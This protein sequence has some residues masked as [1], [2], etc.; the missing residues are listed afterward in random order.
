M[1]FRWSFCEFGEAASVQED[2]AHAIGQAVA[3]E[4][5]LQAATAE[6]ARPGPEVSAAGSVRGE[7]LQLPPTRRPSQSTP[8]VSWR[9][10]VATSRTTELEGTIPAIA[11]ME[12][13]LPGAW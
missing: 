4:V 2:M 13:R 10:C 8:G 6:P 5:C 3:R 7:R 1:T 11:G 12:C 9:A